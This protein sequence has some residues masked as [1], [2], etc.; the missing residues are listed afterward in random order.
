[1]VLQYFVDL[2]AINGKVAADIK[3]NRLTLTSN[4][5]VLLAG[6]VYG[7]V[8]FNIKTVNSIAEQNFIFLLFAVL[9]GFLYMVSSQIGITLLLW[10]MCRLLKGR[11]PFMALF[12]AIGYAFIPYGILAVLIAYFNGAVLTN[13]LL[14]ILA[15]LVLL[16]LVQMLAKIIFVIEDFSLKKAYMCVVFSMIFFGSFI[17]VFGY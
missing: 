2:V 12:S 10:A 17:Y 1:M 3:D 8:I 4:L 5:I 13:Y 6:V 11:V 7:L 15:A 14:G 9:L 16:W